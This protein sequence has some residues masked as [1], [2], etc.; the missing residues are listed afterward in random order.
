[1]THTPTGNGVPTARGHTTVP[2]QRTSEA[3]AGAP[4]RRRALAERT[5]RVRAAATTEPGR[6]RITGA[7]LALLV[8]LFGGVTAWQVTG[9]AAAAEDVVHHSAPLSADAA[10]IYRSLA[11]ADTTAAGGFLA[12][13]QEPKSVRDRYEK[14]IRTASRLI[15]EAAAD[16]V[17]TSEA[18]RQVSLLNQ[19]LPVY[20]G[21]VETARA[22]NRQGLPLGGAYLRYAD[23]QM[24]KDGGLLDAAKKLYELETVH[25]GEDYADA[26]ALPWV[27]WTVGVIALAALVW[28]QRR[29][30][31]RTNRVFNRG[32]LAASAA[33]AVMLLWLVA[34]H[35]VARA[36]LDDSY[37]HGAHSL[38]VLNSARIE[39]LQ[40][41][42]DENLTLVTRGAGKTYDDSFQTG[43]TH[44]AGEDEKAGGGELERALA[45]ADDEAGRT[46]VT[47]AIG[48]VRTWRGRHRTA[49]DSDN[50]GDYETAVAQVIGGKDQNG[51]VVTKTT[52]QCFDTVDASLAEAVGHEQQEFER[53]A[54]DGRGALAG[55]PLGAAVLALLGAAGAALGIGRR[56]SEYR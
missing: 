37:T 51:T 9:R 21:L 2:A 11:D 46:P 33:S 45:L 54:S 17:A 38:Q 10:E 34:G 24:R 3:P 50:A 31:R 55:L 12:G 22:N 35:T 28:V 26:K 14:D 29:L 32:L 44:L 53:A 23:E 52:G 25:L 8:V 56:L 42:G 48:G 16:T 36:Q 27:A 18:A 19:Q 20:T 15:A 49:R 39:A 30:Y 5:G 7:V 47:A 1:M 41:R 13:G 40:A 43:M 6:L 4:S